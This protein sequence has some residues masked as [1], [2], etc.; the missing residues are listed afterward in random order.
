MKNF[1][2]AIALCLALLLCL[3]FPV[4]ASA[5]E[6]EDA[7]IDTTAK[8]SLTIYKYNLTGAEK[9]GVWDS[10]YV[11]TGI[12]DQTV[13]DTLKNYTLQGVE[14]SYLRVADIVQFTE[15]AADGVDFDHVE[16]LYGIDKA[17]GAA[18][19]SAIGLAD[20]AKR[21]ENADK[22]DSGKF[23][24]QADVLVSALSSALESNSTTVKN[25]LDAY[26]SSN[27]GTALPLT[28]TYGKTSAS[29]L[30]LGLYLVVE[31]KVPEMVT[32]TCNPFLI[33]L[34]MT[35]GDGNNWIYDVTVYPK[36]LTGV[37]TLDKTLRE[38]KDDTGKHDGTSG[39]T[40]GYA[41]TGTA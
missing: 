36:N 29:D 32:S 30:D 23:Y 9:D 22:L 13:I 27:G 39:I 12:A 40:D 31:T 17:K 38:N 21:Y 24:Y 14:F 25:A 10:S 19:L 8:G 26:V 33:S 34:P 35:S 15:S 3:S 7:T 1:T 37:P 6:M 20:G 2:K 4:G 11:S 28:D 16:V 41:S 18:L 5:A